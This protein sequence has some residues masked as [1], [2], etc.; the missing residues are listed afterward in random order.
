MKNE[1]VIIEM[2]KQISTRLDS[3]ESRQAAD[4]KDMIGRFTSMEQ[5]QFSDKKDMMDRFT[6]MEQKQFADK[7]EMMDKIS[8]FEANANL[9]FSSMENT[10]THEKIR[11]DAVF[12]ERKQVEV[13]FSRAF[14]GLNS[15]FAGMIALVV[16]L[17][18]K[19]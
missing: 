4:K 1:E 16:S 17:F 11:L 9:H 15:V 18:T 3:M 12:D 2:L 13:K 7:K 5:R 6:S 14:V 19:S 8:S 10:L